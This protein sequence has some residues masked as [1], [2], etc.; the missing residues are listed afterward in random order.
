MIDNIRILYCLFFIII[1]FTNFIIIT[2]IN[3][4]TFV[5]IVIVIVSLIT[6]VS[7]SFLPL[8]PSILRNLVL[9]VIQKNKD[10]KKTK[11]C[12]IVM[13]IEEEKKKM[14]TGDK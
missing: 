2:S 6:P 10:Y 12:N 4:N 14:K 13:Q 5:I 3:V 9:A 8:L 11:I 1:L 7:L